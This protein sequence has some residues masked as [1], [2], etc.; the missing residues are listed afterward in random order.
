[1][2]RLAVV[3]AVAVLVGPAAEA[4]DSLRIRRAG[5]GRAGTIVRESVA[6]PHRFLPADTGRITL[7]RD[8]VVEGSLI[9]A[10]G[11]IAV[12]ARV[13]GDVVVIG[14]DLYM[15]PGGA[16][17]GRAA[18]L[19]GC[20]Y[21]STLATIAGE[22]ECDRDV[23]YAVRRAPPFVDVSYVA[24]SEEGIPAVSVPFPAGLRI[25]TYTR[26]DGLGLPWGPRVVLAGG[27]VE[28]DPTITYRSAIGEIDPGLTV[29]VGAR[30]LWFLELEGGRGTRTNDAWIRSDPLNSV[31]ALF[32]GRDVRNYYRSRYAVVRGGRRWERGATLL[33][34][35][36]GGQAERDRSTHARAPWSAFNRRD[37]V[38]GMARPNPPVAHGDLGSVLGGARLMWEKGGVELAAH[39]ETERVLDAP[40]DARFTQT[41]GN[42]TVAFATFGTQRL[43]FETH[44][45]WTAGRRA[46]PQR[47]AYVGGSGTITT[48]DLLSLG[49]DQL[50]FV[51]S[52]YEIPI[53]RLR[54]PFSGP[55]V[56]TLR[57]AMGSAGLDSLPDL[58]Q[59]VGVRVTLRPLRVDFAHDP[60]TGDSE[61]K[62]GV[63]FG[64]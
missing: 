11:D 57:H 63:S 36:I 14:G 16:I 12:G 34:A 61:V 30:T 19:G 25:P 38:E 32:A 48:R 56:V 49:G 24:P 53:E 21:T 58:V 31:I 54:I 43:T 27:L 8:T 64:R 22:V 50:L 62:V 20:V 60:S 40:E 26:V 1:V 15:H 18:A 6:A 39:V 13:R 52:R 51:E 44:G 35:W 17:E 41:T 45:V 3:L 9:V 46:V 37:S 4:Q 33:S 28:I 59:N 10:G 2:R 47:F 7:P 5:P 29:V 23:H 42:L 55:P